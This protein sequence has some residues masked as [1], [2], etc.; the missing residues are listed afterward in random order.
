MPDASPKRLHKFSTSPYY[1]EKFETFKRIHTQQNH[2]LA[3]VNSMY[4]IKIQKL[5]NEV[6]ALRNENLELRVRLLHSEHNVIQEGTIQDPPEPEPHICDTQLNNRSGDEKRQ[7]DGGQQH[8]RN[9]EVNRVA[10]RVRSPVNYALPS[11]K[12]KLRKGDPYTFKTWPE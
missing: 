10:R 8:N 5:E 1:I 6:I 12:R 3:R 4:A 11:I 7:S 2:E 9:T